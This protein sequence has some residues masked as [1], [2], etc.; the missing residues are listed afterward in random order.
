MNCAIT[1]I[2][3][4]LVSVPILAAAEDARKQSTSTK[5]DIMDVPFRVVEIDELELADIAYESRGP[6]TERQE[7]E[8]LPIDYR[9]LVR[10]AVADFLGPPDTI[11]Q[12]EYIVFLSVFEADPDTAL[13]EKLADY[14]DK[15]RPGS[16]FEHYKGRDKWHY[17]VYVEAT[18]PT[19]G[20]TYIV[21]MGYSCGGMCEMEWQLE[22]AV[23]D[24]KLVI[25]RS[26]TRWVS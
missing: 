20:E 22:I 8:G 11:E 12:P 19:D 9:D 25:V 6:N 14:G 3:I 16:K 7:A 17:F 26:R 2:L 4:V 13:F 23:K 24:N 18:L 1:I 5:V 15:I 21:E 10:V